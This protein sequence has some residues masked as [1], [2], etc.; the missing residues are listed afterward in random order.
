MGIVIPFGSFISYIMEVIKIIIIITS[1]FNSMTSYEV[2]LIVVPHSYPPYVFLWE[3]DKVQDNL[4]CHI[5]WTEII[6]MV[7][8]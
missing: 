4:T 1:T 3:E 2:T 7:H 5:I 8:N 6:F